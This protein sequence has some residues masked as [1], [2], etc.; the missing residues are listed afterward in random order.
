MTD[1]IV[2]KGVRGGLELRI[3][4]TQEFPV[5]RNHLKNKLA[6][7]GSFFNAGME[8]TVICVERDL[9]SK[10]ITTI[11]T[12]ISENALILKEVRRTIPEPPQISLFEEEESENL[13]TVVEL[14]EIEE[15]NPVQVEKEDREEL[16]L[17]ETDPILFKS[18]EEEEGT[19][20]YRRTLR[21]GQVLS[22]SGIIVI[23][24]DV[25]PGAEVIAGSNVFIQGSCRGVI[26]A[27]VPDNR[28]A[29]ITATNLLATQ[30]RIA[31]VIARSPDHRE[32]PKYAERASVKDGRIFIEKV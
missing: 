19:F 29:T 13:E 28:E 1:V 4:G 23:E 5:I 20:V 16:Y 6:I 21:N 9:T 3:D 22:Y 15:S 18:G 31:D 8:V 32:I 17:F 11:K 24:G 30:I 26:H 27:G 25:N 2:F 12:L 7:S 10:E 14:Q